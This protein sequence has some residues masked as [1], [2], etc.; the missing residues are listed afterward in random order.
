MPE[1]EAA[2]RGRPTEISRWRE[3]LLAAVRPGGLGTVADTQPD[4][5]IDGRYRLL[6][7][8]GQ[9][10]MGTIWSAE[11]AGTGQRVAVKFLHPQASANEGARE[12]FLREGR[13]AASIDHP[14]V[15]RIFD[16][17]ETDD[18]RSFLS[19]E[20]LEAPN[21]A[22]YVAEHGPLP[23]DAV[24]ALLE[25][26]TDALAAV[27]DLGIVHRDVKPTNIMVTLEDAAPRCKLI[28][29]GLA[30]VT[31]ASLSLTQTGQLLGSPAYMSPEQFRGED[32]D[33]R[34]DVYGLGCTAYFMRTGHRPFL[35]STPAEVMYQHLSS[36]MPSL[37]TSPAD[38]HLDDVIRRACAKD[39]RDRF[40]SMRAFQAAL[41]SAS[42][43]PVDSRRGLFLAL[44]AMTLV[45]GTAASIFARRPLHHAEPPPPLVAAALLP[46][47]L[48]EPPEVRSIHAGDGFTCAHLTDDTFRCWGRQGPHMCRPET[49]GHVGDDELPSSVPALGFAG[50]RIESLETEYYASHVCA[51]LDDRTLRCW[52]D[53]RFG[54]LGNGPSK[55]HWCDTKGESLATLPALDL[56]PVAEVHTHQYGTCALAG[57][58]TLGV[59]CWGYN[60]F[61]Q[62]G[63][64]H[65][66]PLSEPPS[67]PAVLG[68]EPVTTM[69]MGIHTACA[70][71]GDGSLRCWGANHSRQLASGLPR[72]AFVGDGRG[73]GSRGQ[74]PDTPDLNVRGLEDFE[75]AALRVNGGWNCVLS[76]QG[77]VRCWGGNHRGAVG[78]PYDLIPGCD[79]STDG[80][81]CLVGT[82]HH[83]VDL[84]DVRVV[85][86]QMGRLRACALDDRGQVR[87]WGMG[88]DGALGYGRAL[89]R[90]GAQDI[91][92]Q[93]SPRAAY[94]RMETD[95]V[96][97]IGD[98]DDDGRIDR[99]V[100]LAMGYSH[101]CV[102]V[103]DGSV[104]CWGSN[105]EG[106]LGYGT[107]DT[108]GDDETPAEYYA[109]HGCGRVP[110]VAGTGCARASTTNEPAPPRP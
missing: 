44:G 72:N 13:V 20:L 78:V 35:G 94:A 105:A 16:V 61:G 84:G 76:T 2:S 92:L 59:Y 4:L 23:P 51:L 73:D 26:L 36:P 81:E 12:R 45:G 89:E 99:V 91:G 96:V 97:D 6:E 49:P 32:A 87:C 29:F 101:S 55:N 82:P 47:T 108:I 43:A 74:L 95:G 17:A 42:A 25:Q 11:H 52:G 102:L 38:Q 15:V 5:L 104:R 21:L 83:D 46:E 54:Q 30:G 41:R 24:C 8:L 10:G 64:G 58:D 70:G 110:I 37:G 27:H 39:P 3:A 80:S 28:D 68:P 9:G 86:L 56:P 60:R 106:E 107:T 22:D 69:G 93:S 53:D 85:D 40:A 79:P 62:A 14:S 48:D 57:T 63:L 18:G 71:F 65:R 90:T 34:A 88:D 31:E 19:M 50:H 33:G 66:D 1:V 100:Q 98:F 109:N 67:T 103:E 7:Q 75:V 77:Q